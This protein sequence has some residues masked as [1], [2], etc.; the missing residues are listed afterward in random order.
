MQPHSDV[1]I[2]STLLKQ[3]S[4]GDSLTT[5]KKRLSLEGDGDLFVLVNV[6]MSPF[7]V[8]TSFISSLAESFKR[9]ANEVIQQVCRK[10]LLI[11][12]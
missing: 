12:V 11:Q 3:S 10:R 2:M 8:E 4:L 6:S 1:W 5:F 9:T 7:P